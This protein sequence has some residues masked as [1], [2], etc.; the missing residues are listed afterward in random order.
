M[1]KRD[2]NESL[3]RLFCDDNDE[4]CMRRWICDN[5][6]ETFGVLKSAIEEV[7]ARLETKRVCL[8]SHITTPSDFGKTISEHPSIYNHRSSKLHLH[9]GLQV[10]AFG[11]FLD[12]MKSEESVPS[13]FYCVASELMQ[14]M[15][16]PF[17]SD[18]SRVDSLQYTIK[19]L[20]DNFN[21]L[22]VQKAGY[23]S[24]GVIQDN[25]GNSLVN[26]EYK[27]EIFGNSTCPN[28]QNIGYFIHMKKGQTGCSPMLL[29]SVVGCH[30]LQV[31]GA[32]WEK[33]KR[34]CEDPLSSPVSLVFVPRDPNHGV[35]KVAKLL[36]AMDR[37][38]TA[39]RSHYSS[40]VVSTGGPYWTVE[41]LKYERRMTTVPWLFDASY[42][43]EKV[44]VK[45]VRDHYG[46]K[47]HSFLAGKNLAPKLHHCERLVG[48]WYVVIMEK[49]E[50]RLLNENTEAL[51]PIK[52]S[53][54]RAV[55]E[56]HK[57]GMVHGDLRPQNILITGKASSY[58]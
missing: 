2:P 23:R 15:T 12:I 5:N 39:L 32:V 56:M 57:N 18:A 41:G 26:W 51:Q 31:F 6:D 19:K 45:F 52:E 13:Q 10:R 49:V 20:G 22:P 44:V 46:D 4:P 43:D 8:E 1:K 16:P 34:V 27:N 50:G 42:K 21:F 7:C 37:A 35:T 54:N 55:Q 28:Q 25:S 36:F 47:V 48:G 30:Y 53:L 9:V 40:S 14:K 38:I 17:Q 11:Q 29:V 58:T 33:E 3:L 24:D